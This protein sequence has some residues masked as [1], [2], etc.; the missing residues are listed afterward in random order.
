VKREAKSRVIFLMCIYAL[1]EHILRGVRLAAVT[2]ARKAGAGA[3]AG[4]AA[5]VGAYRTVPP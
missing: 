2:S 4:S 1:F 3:G 5:G